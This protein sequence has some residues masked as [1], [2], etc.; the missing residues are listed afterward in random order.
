MSHLRFACH[1]LPKPHHIHTVNCT[2]MFYCTLSTTFESNHICCCYTTLTYTY[3]QHTFTLSLVYFT[4]SLYPSL[5]AMS[6][7]LPH[8]F[9]HIYT[10]CPFVTLAW[11][12]ATLL[13]IFQ[14]LIS[15]RLHHSSLCIYT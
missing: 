8:Q 13:T 3:L 15:T 6:N 10:Y 1:Y 5:L 11:R 2:C 9:H 14:C 12:H 7:S 4:V